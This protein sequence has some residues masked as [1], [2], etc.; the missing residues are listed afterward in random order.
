[1]AAASIAIAA[2]PPLPETEPSALAS[3]ISESLGHPFQL[4]SNYFPER[5][6]RGTGGKFEEFVCLC[7]P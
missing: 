1:M 6:P 4:S 7:V 2:L 5:I 3:S